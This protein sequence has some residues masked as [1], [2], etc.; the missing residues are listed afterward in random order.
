M[1][2]DF[3]FAFD[4]PFTL[5]IMQGGAGLKLHIKLFYIE[6]GAQLLTASLIFKYLHCLEYF[7]PS[8]QTDEE[9]KD[10]KIAVK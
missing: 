3:V 2:H 4:F 1:K 10:T 9:I 7:L 8:W 6:D 5:K